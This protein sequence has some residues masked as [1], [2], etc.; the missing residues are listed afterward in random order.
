[1][2]SRVSSQPSAPGLEWVREQFFGPDESAKT[3]PE[4]FKAQTLARANAVSRAL[5]LALHEIDNHDSPTE[6]RAWLGDGL[7]RLRARKTSLDAGCETLA[8]RDVEV[9]LRVVLMGRTMAGKS[10]LFEFLSEGD[11]ARVGDGGQRFSRDATARVAKGLDIEVV[12]TPGVGAMDGLE[13][14]E[15]AFGEVANAD[16]ILWVATDQATQEQTGRALEALADLGKP[17]LV[18]LNCLKDV[19]D[20]IGLLDILEDPDLI[21]GGDALGNLAPIRRHLARAGGRYVHAVEIHAQGALLSIS[22]SLSAEESATLYSNSRI[23]SLIDEL[24]KQAQRTADQRRLVSISD[25]IRSELMDTMSAIEDAHVTARRGV[26]AATG[27]RRDFRARGLRRVDDACDELKAS[28]DSAVTSRERWAD[29]VDV[30][31]RLDVLNRN[32]DEEFERLRAELVSSVSAISGALES[33]LQMI[34]VDVGEDWASFDT[35]SFRGLN[36]RASIWGNRVVKTGGRF[37]IGLGGL[38]LGA[39]IGA[40][41]GTAL[42]PGPG[43]AIGLVVGSVVGPVAALLGANKLIDWIG[44]KTFRSAEEVHKRRREK[45]GAQMSQLLEKL[46]EDLESASQTVRQEWLDAVDSEVSRLSASCATLQSSAEVLQQVLLEY[47]EPAIIQID[48]ELARDLLRNSGHVRAASAMTRATRWRG[49]GI[50]IEL[51]EAAYSELVLFPIDETVDRII[52]TSASGFPGTSALQIIRRLTDQALTINRLT[53]DE[54][55]VTLDANP[56]S[57]IVEAW[58]A[59]AT[60]HTGVNVHIRETGGGQL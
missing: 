25:S 59:L 1:V 46:R 57:G 21:F 4:T 3:V 26:A 45:V 23:E 39:Q 44:D 52:P 34:A 5:E 54:L 9:P 51:P 18:A 2:T 31:Q 60:V 42:G 56:A 17:I 35:G 12:D 30:D 37:A 38:Y 58:E 41:V 6:H 29:H 48:T 33:D 22:G 8:L 16:L 20:E 36:S 49:A 32:L 55:D 15:T 14:Y 11:G 53:A 27:L 7:E 43:T 10:T 50:A 24:R 13:D 47:F 19:S 28:F 40:W